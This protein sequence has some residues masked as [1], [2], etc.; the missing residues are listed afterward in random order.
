MADPAEGGWRLRPASTAAPPS[1]RGI[2]ETPVSKPLI[3]S[4]SL[5]TLGERQR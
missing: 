2:T 1:I 4:A 3:P 5:G